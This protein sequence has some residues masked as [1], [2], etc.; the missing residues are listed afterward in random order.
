MGPLLSGWIPSGGMSHH[1]GGA[2]PGDA[3]LR[4]G[5]TEP[6]DRAL[7]GTALMALGVYRSCPAWSP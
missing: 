7:L 1:H 5:T 6:E 4:H 2:L 3:R